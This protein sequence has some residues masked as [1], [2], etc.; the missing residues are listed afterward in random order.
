MAQEYDIKGMTARIRA[1]RRQATALKAISGGIPAVERNADRIL[2]SVRLL[3]M[4][5][6]EA[7]KFLKKKG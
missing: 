3:E 7:A 2:A 4:N 5:I 6:S 1:L